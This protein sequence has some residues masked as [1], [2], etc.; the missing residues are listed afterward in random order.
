MVFFLNF[1]IVEPIGNYGDIIAK[2]IKKSFIDDDG[3]IREFSMLV[4]NIMLKDGSIVSENWFD[5]YEYD[6]FG[7]CIIGFRRSYA[8]CRDIMTIP[9]YCSGPFLLEQYEYIYGAI[10]PE[11]KLAVK[12]LYDRLSFNNE[13]SYTAYHN[14]KLGYV[15]STDGKHIT[16]IIFTHAQPFFESKAA[17]EYNGKMGYVDRNKVITNPNNKWEYAIEPKFDM[18]DDFD[19]GRAEVSIDGL[20]YTINENGQ[21]IY[22]VDN[23]PVLKKEKK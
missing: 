9:S 7:N 14:G 23:A 16:P 22:S 20:F 4:Y 17:V 11:G 12:P 3:D 21:D 1:D 5:T 2:N 18:T 15:S 19:N 10:N 8:E 6:R 13:N